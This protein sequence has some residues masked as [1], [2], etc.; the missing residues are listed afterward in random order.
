MPRFV[1]NFPPDSMRLSSNIRILL[2]G[3]YVLL[4]TAYLFFPPEPGQYPDRRI[5]RFKL[6]KPRLYSAIWH[7]KLDLLAARQ[8]PVLA[9]PMIAI[10]SGLRHLLL[11]HPP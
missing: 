11:L 7:Q 3:P 8:A 6:L 5:V 2:H 9:G 1:D 10:S 4:D